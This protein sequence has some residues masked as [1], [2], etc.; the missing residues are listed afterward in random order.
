MFKHVLY[1]LVLPIL[2]GSL[3]VFFIATIAYSYVHLICVNHLAKT[4]LRDHFSYDICY[5]S[6]GRGIVEK[7]YNRVMEEQHRLMEEW[8]EERK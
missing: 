7:E 2:G 4:D 8:L 1:T 3:I 5:T 6:N